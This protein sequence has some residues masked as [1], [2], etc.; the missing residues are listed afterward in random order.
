MTPPR[1]TV[2][3][4]SPCGKPTSLV[5]DFEPTVGRGER[6]HLMCPIR[7]RLNPHVR[8]AHTH[9][10]KWACRMGL[11]DVQG[12]MYG[13]FSQARF[14]WLAGRAYPNVDAGRLGL[15][16][17]WITFLF[18]YDDMCDTEEAI[19]GE[20]SSKLFAA[21]D[22]LIAI[23]LG[24]SIE[25]GSPLDRA[26]ADI[27]DRAASI[28]SSEWIARLGRHVHDYIEGVRWERMLRFKG[29][30]PTLATYTKLRLLNSA[31]YPC[32]D[33]AGMCVN[34]LRMDFA[35]NIHVQQLEVMA[36]NH[37]CW[38]NDIYG[39]DKELSEHTT[40]NVII[41]L[42]NEFGLSW[43]QAIDRA[44]VMC[45]AE[46]DAFTELK[47]SMIDLENPNCRAYVEALESWMRGNL[48]WYSETMRYGVDA[49][50]AATWNAWTDWD[51]FGRPSL[52]GLS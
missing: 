34:G 27:R 24:A 11:V 9:T 13:Q 40:S 43:G 4:T 47:E 41:V 18:F 30:V 45:N 21:E 6:P 28:G 20:Y 50:Q 3:N 2:E 35:T 48:D 16:S 33:F 15:M 51:S 31:V 32:L 38:V 1:T 22:R 25:G 52:R 37:I 26:L 49:D 46:L 44:I 12:Q 5:L 19:D 10:L 7:S 29:R 14:S 39:L 42:T 17:D 36:N 8:A 23:G